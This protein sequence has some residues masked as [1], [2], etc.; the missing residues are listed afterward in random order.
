MTPEQINIAIAESV[1]WKCPNE[2]WP[3][4]QASPDYYNDLNAIHEVMMQL[5]LK[6]EVERGFRWATLNEL[7]YELC[8]YSHWDTAH[9]TAAQRCES[10][11]RTIG[12][13]E[14]E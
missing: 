2:W 11:L 4:E 3:N 12:K 8:N 9:A 5:R 10:Y 6:A 14:G 7:L 13:W 1:G